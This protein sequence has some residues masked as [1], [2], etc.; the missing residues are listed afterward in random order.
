[1]SKKSKKL[2]L[3]SEKD[4]AEIQNRLFLKTREAWAKQ[5]M[6]DKTIGRRNHRKAMK[7]IAAAR[8][9]IVPKDRRPEF[10]EFLRIT[11][12]GDHPA[13]LRMF[14]HAGKLLGLK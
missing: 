11:G 1:M 13:M 3:Y 2:V 7:T 5:V 10:N 14:Y 6:K 4:I 12:A 8:D 9:M